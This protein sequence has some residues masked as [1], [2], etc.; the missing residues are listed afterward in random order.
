MYSII[1]IEKTFEAADDSYRTVIYVP[2]LTYK[3]QFPF[4]MKKLYNWVWF[5]H[6]SLITSYYNMHVFHISFIIYKTSS[7]KSFPFA[8]NLLDMYVFMHVLL[9][10]LEVWRLISELEAHIDYR[11]ACWLRASALGNTQSPSFSPSV[12]ATHLWFEKCI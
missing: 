3:L 8:S 9:Q 2:P 1:S 12:T 5:A 10:V 6:L 4:D 7:H 11:P